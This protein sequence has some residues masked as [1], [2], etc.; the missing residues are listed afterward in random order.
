MG[1]MRTIWLSVRFDCKHTVDFEQSQVPGV[2][3]DVY[4]RQCQRMRTV[5]E[6]SQH[7]R[8]TCSGCKY[9]R[10]FGRD[11]ESAKLAASRHVTKMST[12]KVSLKDGPKLVQVYT[13]HSGGIMADML[14]SIAPQ[15]QQILRDMED[16]LFNS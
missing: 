4:C 7:Y 8:I 1:A 15:H 13:I 12:H 2:D 10:S 6:I 14:T 16:R 3:E 5:K 9:S 11:L